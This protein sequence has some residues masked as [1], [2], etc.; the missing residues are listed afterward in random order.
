V[1]YQ[2]QTSTVNVKEL[3]PGKMHKKCDRICKVNQKICWMHFTN[4]WSNVFLEESIGCQL[5]K[6]LL[7]S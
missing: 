4:S 6:E 1:V 3:A 2:R 7:T 5:V